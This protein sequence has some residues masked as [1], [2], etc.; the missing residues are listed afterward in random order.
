MAEVSWKGSGRVLEALG[1]VWGVWE[2]GGGFLE[3]SCD[4]L[5]GVLGGAGGFRGVLGRCLGGPGKVLG[6]C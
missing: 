2:D 6:R 5:E 4:V 1:R 3:G